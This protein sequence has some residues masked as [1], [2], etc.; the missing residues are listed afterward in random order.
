MNFFILH[1][2]YLLNAVFLPDSFLYPFFYRINPWFNPR[3]HL[4]EQVWIFLT[5][6]PLTLICMEML[7]GYRPLLEQSYTRIIIN[8]IV[9]PAAGLGIISIT[10]AAVKSYEFS[11]LIIFSFAGF[12]AVGLCVYRIAIRI[13]FAQRQAAGCYAKNVALIGMPGGLEFMVQHLRKK[14]FAIDYRL[15][16]YLNLP[17]NF[18]LSLNALRMHNFKKILNIAS[19][20]IPQGEKAPESQVA[21]SKNQILQ[22]NTFP[23]Y[24]PKL[25]GNVGDLGELLVHYPI[26]EV[27][28]IYPISGG[29]WLQQVI[30]DCEY[31]AVTLRIIPEALILENWKD[32]QI[33]YRLD[34]LQLPSIVMKHRYLDSDALFFKRLFDIVFSA[35]LLIILSPLFLLIALAIKITTPHLQIFYPWQV[36]GKNGVE[37]TGYKFTTM[38]ADA[39]KLKETLQDRNEMRGP[40]FKI[41]NDPRITSLGRFLRKFSL[42]ELPQLW[43]VLK[44][45]MSLVGPRPA[46]PHELKRYELWHKR[47]LSLWPGITCLWQIRGRNKISN[48]DDW[49]RMDLEY[50]DNWS[51]WLDFKILIRTIGVVFKG[52]GS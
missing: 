43:S 32:M 21:F 49:V 39:D 25:L 27:I 5:M 35:I 24:Q 40:V 12:S 23:Q 2:P 52:T 8:C 42:N 6:A 22:N 48:F 50:I 9:A 3:W 31:F 1:L 41:K 46:G 45:D 11:R 17:S 15:M 34:A 47:K 37:F 26:Q 4:L 20:A 36:I 7:N 44:G 10:M 33:F 38:V 16:G 19:V 30:R 28:V 29:D 13:Y 14:P 18:S 51:L